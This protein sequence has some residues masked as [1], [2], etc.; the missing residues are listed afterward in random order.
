MVVRE[1]V[2]G[3]WSRRSLLAV[4]GGFSLC[5]F[6]DQG[7]VYPPEIEQYLDPATEFPVVRLTN[8]AFSSYL[9]LPGSPAVGRGNDFLI[10]SS[11]RAGAWQ[12]FRM[13]FKTGESRMLT[14]AAE[15]DR[16]TLC[17]QNDERGICYFDGR[18]LRQTLLPSLRARELYRVPDGWT[19]GQRLSLAIDSL[20]AAFVETREKVFRLRLL[21]LANGA[22]ATLA[23]GE[24]PLDAPAV[25]RGRASVLYRRGQGELWL[26]NYDGRQNRRL[27]TAP[28][29]A[30][31]A[32]WSADGRSFYYL[33]IPEEP[34]KLSE[35]REHVPDA[36][37]DLL[38]SATSQFAT[39]TP[40]RDGSV[41][42]GA[43]SSKASPYVLILL[44]VT[45]RELTLAE[46][47]STD[48]VSV[49]PV[50]SNNS[51]RVY[52]GSDRHGKPAIYMMLLDRFVEK[53]ET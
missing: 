6:G 43:S 38:I 52:F 15:F 33:L 28:G 14:A 10:Y 42:V 7:A 47:R 53:T 34:G 20:H 41:F 31:P 26:V 22:A 16:E 29:R 11:D 40:N 9:P 51:Q 44:R 18:S 12:A 5:A 36:N 35:I 23:E 48:P 24:A 17:L 46:H 2:G 8:P 21:T 50:F 37:S 45:H 1:C 19:R 32:I 25:R 4:L 3:Q 27:K 49:S 13:D 39:F 30:G